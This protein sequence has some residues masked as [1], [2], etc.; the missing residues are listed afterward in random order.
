MTPLP[1]ARACERPGGLAQAA[2]H[3]VAIIRLGRPLFL[4][5]GFVSYGLGAAAAR[6]AG[7]PLD[8]GLLVLGQVVVTAFQLMT[9]YCN[10]YFDFEA[11]VANATPTRWSGGS[12]VLCAG[13]LPRW[14]ALVAALLLAA[15]GLGVTAHLAARPEVPPLAATL[16]LLMGLLSWEYSAPPL[17]LHSAG[18]G[19][20]D[21]AVVVTGLVPLFGY[22]LQAPPAL[23]ASPALLALV[24]P[25]LL[26]FAMVLAV[27]FPDAEA[28]ARVGKRTLVVRLG[29]ARAAR[30][31]AAVVA[32][33]YLVLPLLV[34]AGLPIE[35]AV[36]A[37]LPAPIA[38]WRIGRLLDGDASRP[39]R[40]EAVTFWAV[41]LLVA[42]SLAELAALL[43]IG[44][45]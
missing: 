32:A 37:A 42:T 8:L 30:L 1:T 9:H 12:R 23:G 6:L 22:L 29:A 11:D 7:A 5:G 2:A 14:V 19:E 16:G 13:A 15:V 10:D 38:L 40:F 17:T 43:W 20:I 33:A 25:F 21:A 35:V 45:R 28:D 31:W 44:P 27:A 41:A 36:A 18:L 26:Q 39:A 24:P 34:A 4:A 3:A